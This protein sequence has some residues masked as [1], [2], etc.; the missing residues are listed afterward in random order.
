MLVWGLYS[1]TSPIMPPPQWLAAG[2]STLMI[3]ASSGK[4]QAF[5][6]H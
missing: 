6:M 4:P 5:G 2:R 1:R 3:L